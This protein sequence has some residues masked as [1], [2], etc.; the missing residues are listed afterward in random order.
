ML[1]IFSDAER[2]VAVVV[3]A[4]SGR[5]TARDSLPGPVTHLLEVTPP[6][7]EH[8][9]AFLLAALPPPKGSP[10]GAFL[11]PRGANATWA[12]DQLHFWNFELASGAV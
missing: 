7:D 8:R 3:N 4:H 9:A 1:A 6:A 2:A 11:W 12:A 10:P 5:I